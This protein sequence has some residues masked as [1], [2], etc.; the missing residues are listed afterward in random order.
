MQR[1]QLRFGIL[2]LIS[3]V[4]NSVV[5]PALSEAQSRAP[6]PF[7]VYIS[8]DMEGVSGTVNEA[9]VGVEADPDNQMFRSIMTAEVNAAVEA[10]LQAG[11]T[12]IVVEEHHGARGFRN[13]LL[14]QLHPNAQLIRGWP[15]PRGGITGLDSSFKAAIFLGYHA[16]EGTPRAVM[17]HTFLSGEVADFRINDRSVGEGEF[18]AIV[19]GALGVPVVLVS[20]DDVVVVQMR[21]FLGDVEGTVVKKALS[22]TSALVMAPVASNSLIKSQTARALHR[23]AQFRPVKIALPYRAEFTFKPKA[24]ERIQRIAKDHP[25]FSQTTPRSLAKTCQTLD[26][27]INFYMVALGIELDSSPSLKR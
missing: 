13:I 24:D 6:R 22:R 7:K 16:R 17:S 21:E 23:F 14:D 11:A 3:F 9:D 18:N 26:E 2:V 8:V 5:R 25:E 1:R 10:A 4:A 12:E 15:R 20:G 19:A 27:L